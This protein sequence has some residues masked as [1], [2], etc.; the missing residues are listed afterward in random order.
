MSTG[1]YRQKLGAFLEKDYAKR[2]FLLATLS[3]HYPNPVDN[4]TTK[5]DLT[6]AEVQ[7]RMQMI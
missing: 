5:T 1:S 3:Q 7:H 4:L 2:D 6:Y